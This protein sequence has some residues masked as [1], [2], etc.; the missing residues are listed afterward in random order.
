MS[1]GR[2]PAGK[3]DADPWWKV[4]V[5]WHCLRTEELVIEK[6]EVRTWTHQ[7]ILRHLPGSL[8]GENP[9]GG[10]YQFRTFKEFCL[11]DLSAEESL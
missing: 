6:G 7:S 5:S 4:S 9:M 8:K 1:S 2:G 3:E 10:P 11:L